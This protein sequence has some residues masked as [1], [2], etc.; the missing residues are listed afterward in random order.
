MTQL[1]SVSVLGTECHV[2]KSHRPELKILK[3][4]RWLSGLKHWFA[5]S[6]YNEFYIMGSNPILSKLI[7][8]KY[9]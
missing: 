9:V 7:I 8:K 5:K 6:T 2:F 1:V 4:E 3:I